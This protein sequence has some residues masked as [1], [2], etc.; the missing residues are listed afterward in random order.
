[1][2]EYK[3]KMLKSHCDMD[4]ITHSAQDALSKDALHVSDKHWGAIIHPPEIVEKP[5]QEAVHI[6]MAVWDKEKD[7]KD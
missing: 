7:E 3:Y 2:I 6:T 1:M 5:S 4:S